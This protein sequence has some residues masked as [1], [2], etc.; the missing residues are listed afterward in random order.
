MKY[1]YGPVPSRRL[2]FSLGIDVI[3]YKTCTLNCIYCQ[4]GRTTQKTLDR[5]PYNQKADIL[6]E[7]KDVLKRKQ[8]IDYITFSGSGEPTLNSD[9]GALIKEVKA[10]TS[11]PVAVLTNGTLLFMEDVQKDLMNADVV[12][13]S[14]DAASA[15][16]FRRVNRPHH[17]LEIETILD[18][19]KRF[20]KLFRGRIWLEIML[21]KGLND[22]AEEL[23]CMRNAISEIQPDRVHLN[24]VVRP[25]SL[26]S[27]KPLNRE[28]MAA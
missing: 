15:Q 27:A 7:V 21:I 17:S 13:P 11:L 26:L 28:E 23:L 3:P 18:G 20:R 25:P 14:L 16:V 5:R 4:I 8:Q 10:C 6:K 24:T 2:G 19:L 1:V 22:N 12:L 9:I